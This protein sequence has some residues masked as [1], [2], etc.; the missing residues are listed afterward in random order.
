M[1][2]KR[3]YYEILGVPKTASQDEIKSAFRKKAKQYHPDVNKEKDAE[4]KFKEIGEAYA[5]L[6]DEQKRAQYDQFGHQAFANGGG[7]GTGGFNG[8]GFEDF[9]FS[10]IFDDLFGGAF[11]FGRGNNTRNSNRPRKGE[12]ELYQMKITF[13]EAVFG[14]K[15]T[16]KLNLDEDCPSC[17]GE[18]GFDPITCSTCNGRG[19]VIVEQRSI[20]GV[21]QS[22]SVCKDCGG[23]G[24]S[25]KKVCPECR[26]RKHINVSKEITITIPSGVDNKTQLRLSGKG[27][28]GF[29]GGPNGDLYIEFVVTK[30]PIFE[31]ENDDIYL[32]VPLTIAQ[33]SLGC[34]IEI[35]T[36]EGNVILDIKEGTQTGDKYKLKNKG[37]KR[38]GYSKGNMYVITNVIIPKKLNRKQ[39][40]LLEDLADE[41]L[42]DAPEFKEFRKY[43]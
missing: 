13:D 38:E 9:D 24:K 11:G 19:R 12:D 30:H 23:T 14:C 25:F 27:G 39:R 5:V 36:I 20:F 3:D 29:N 8:T 16:I 34:K 15:K 32:E 4:A 1:A 7:P 42:D 37:I 22:E 10:S 31:R 40:N 6:S 28:A 26:G 2:D 35:P 18:G 33:A 17:N 43:V 21:F 41:G